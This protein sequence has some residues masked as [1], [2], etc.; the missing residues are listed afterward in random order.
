MQPPIAAAVIV[1][2]DRV[3]LVQRREPGPILWALP[4]GEI[5]PGELP[6]R[7]AVRETL[8]ETGLTV[9]AG[10]LL[11]IR[12]HPLTERHMAYIA[13]DVLAGTAHVAA[14]DEL[15]A[16]RWVTL[17]QI[18]EYVPDGLYPPVQAYLDETLG[19]RS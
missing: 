4:G 19:Q 7:A 2:D 16:V 5:E 15:P 8:K 11:G 1:K 17:A 14:E 10:R 18:P 13:C 6:E 3:L 12:V 9:A